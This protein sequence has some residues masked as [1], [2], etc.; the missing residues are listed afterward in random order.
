MLGVCAQQLVWSLRT[1]AGI[2][3]FVPVVCTMFTYIF[4]IEAGAIVSSR[5]DHILPS[6]F[7]LGEAVGL[8]CLLGL[9]AG[10]YKGLGRPAI[11]KAVQID[12]ARGQMLWYAGVGA[13]LV[14]IFG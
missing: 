13:M 5:G 3:G 2:L 1:P 8:L 12:P 4:V 7:A 9:L 14:G 10:W 11:A 6:Y